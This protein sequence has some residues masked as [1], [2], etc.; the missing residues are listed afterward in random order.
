M[1][2]K[3]PVHNNRNGLNSIYKENAISLEK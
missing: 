3:L 1:T 2:S